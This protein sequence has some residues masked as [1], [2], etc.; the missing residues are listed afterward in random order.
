M[1]GKIFLAE[2]RGFC[3]G[4]ERAVK[5][6][7]TAVEKGPFPVRVLHEIVHNE[8]VVNEF[9]ARGVE[10]FEEPDSAWNDGVLILSAH[11]VGEFLFL[12]GRM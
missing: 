11:G 5:M 12:Q 3:S 7:S 1:K 4:V 10:F 9:S 8:S 6:V 2:K